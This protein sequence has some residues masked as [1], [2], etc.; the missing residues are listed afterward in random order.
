MYVCVSSTSCVCV[1]FRAGTTSN[2]I[3]KIVFV[4]TVLPLLLT[5]PEVLSQLQITDEQCQ[6]FM[7]D[8]FCPADKLRTYIMCVSSMCTTTV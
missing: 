6:A 5:L 8:D 2:T 1:S 4:I 7:N 3:M